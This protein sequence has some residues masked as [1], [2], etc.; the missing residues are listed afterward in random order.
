M[1]EG[2]PWGVKATVMLLEN[3]PFR[4]IQAAAA[5]E[6]VK[7][8]LQTLSLHRRHISVHGS[9]VAEDAVAKASNIEILEEIIQK[10]FANR[11]NWKPTISDTMKAL[12]MHFRLTQGNPFDELLDTLASASLGSNDTDSSTSGEQD[13]KEYAGDPANGTVDETSAQLVDDD[14]PEG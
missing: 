9:A 13:T 8:A 3:V 10:G 12:D 7:I 11:K 2:T 14:D 1:R 6:G 5:A 4:K